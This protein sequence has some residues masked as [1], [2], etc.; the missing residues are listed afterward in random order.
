MWTILHH[1]AS[2]SFLELKGKQLFL[3]LGGFQFRHNLFDWGIIDKSRVIRS[4][5]LVK[6]LGLEIGWDAIWG[7]TLS[8]KWVIKGWLQILLMAKSL[9]T[10]NEFSYGIG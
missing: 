6:D 9:L 2:L 1:L 5:F 3:T 7:G 4:H 10:L 8:K